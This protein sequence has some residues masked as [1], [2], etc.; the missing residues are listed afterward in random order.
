M[1]KEEATRLIA[2]TLAETRS[3][4]FEPM[5]SD[6]HDATFLAHKFGAK[7]YITVEDELEKAKAQIEKLTDYLNK[8]HAYIQL[9]DDGTE[10][11]W[12]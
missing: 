9:I 10:E 5:T 12:S 3:H 2:L 8:A 6:W 4:P 1:K 11:G 7:G